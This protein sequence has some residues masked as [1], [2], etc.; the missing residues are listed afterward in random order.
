MIPTVSQLME[1]SEEGL[2]ALGKEMDLPIPKEVTK[3]QIAEMLL[4]KKCFG[5]K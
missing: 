3:I 2:R 1:L 4:G 5:C